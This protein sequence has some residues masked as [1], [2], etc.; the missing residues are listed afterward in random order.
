MGRDLVESAE[1][2]APKPAIVSTVRP[3]VVTAASVLFFVAG[4]LNFGLV[5]YQLLTTASYIGVA[6]DLLLGVICLE[7]GANLSGSRR[8]GAIYGW[9]AS[10]IAAAFDVIVWSSTGYLTSYDVFVAV[11]VA[12]LFVVTALSWPHLHS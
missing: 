6:V 11:F 7:A 2:V 10:I 9:G 4:A 12:V 8:S 3:L 5:I 1:Y